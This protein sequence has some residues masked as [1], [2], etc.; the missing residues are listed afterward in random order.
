MSNNTEGRP[1]N[2]SGHTRLTTQPGNHTVAQME[3]FAK[4]VVIAYKHTGRS[5]RR[6]TACIL[7]HNYNQGLLGREREGEGTHY[8]GSVNIF[9]HFGT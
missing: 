6:E 2:I 3:L 8:E 9:Q 7:L 1:L 4:Q 5:G